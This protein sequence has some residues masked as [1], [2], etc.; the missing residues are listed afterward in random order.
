MGWSGMG[1]HR[2]AGW[3]L[4][5]EDWVRVSV[6]R[7]HRG[8]SGVHR[9]IGFVIRIFKAGPAADQIAQ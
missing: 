8:V 3:H 7:R 9:R 5:V 2:R 4:W 1:G 6:V